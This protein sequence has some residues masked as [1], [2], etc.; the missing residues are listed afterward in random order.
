MP[1]RSNQNFNALVFLPLITYRPFLNT[2]IPLITE[3]WRSHQPLRGLVQSMSAALFE[4]HVLNKPYFDRH[5]LIIAL[6]QDLP[7]GFVHVGFGAN[8]SLSDLD[9]EQAVISMLMVSKSSAPVTADRK[10]IAE[11][12]VEQGEQYAVR[13]QSKSIRGG[14]SYPVNPFYLGIYGGSRLPGIL[15]EDEFT[16]EVFRGLGYETIGECGI[17]QIELSRFRSVMNREQMK[18][19]RKYNIRAEFDPP[20]RHWWEACTLGHAERMK[21]ELIER[22]SD[23]KCG[24]VTFWDMQPL[25]SHWGVH[26]AGMIDILI[27]PAHRRGGLATFLISEA[28]RQLKD[29]GSTVAEVQFSLDDQAISGLF[30]K[31]GFQKID[32]GVSYCKPLV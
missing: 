4:Q 3:I 12:L 17:W 30:E 29:H 15:R 32:H 10:S 18:I 28:L 20:P 24:E 23:S 25:S 11:K 13:S 6:D 14:G 22:S 7:V 26:A 31:L 1:L 8:E 2:D 21:F 27:S 9:R 16:S 5:G 19:R